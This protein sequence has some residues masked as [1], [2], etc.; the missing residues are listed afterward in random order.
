VAELHSI[1][2]LVDDALRV[3]ASGI[4]ERQIR[5]VRQ[6]EP[7]PDWLVDKHRVLQILVNLISNAK[8]A[9]LGSSAPE[10]V[11]T[12]GVSLNGDN[13]L[14]VSVADNGVG[15]S[16]E[17]LNR[18]FRH[19]FTTRPDGH[20]FG[21]HSSILAAREMGGDLL[22]QSEGPGHGAVFTLEIP[23]QPKSE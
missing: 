18:L 9:L 11:L 13:R 6:F 10:R 7:V 22:V 23:N 15:I 17:N 5:V 1:P 14:R 20:G 16:A 2:A 19:G 21:L 8:W 3:H 4:E 12:L